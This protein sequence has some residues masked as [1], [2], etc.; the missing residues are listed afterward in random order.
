M[1]HCKIDSDISIMNI[2]VFHIHEKLLA[3]LILIFLSAFGHGFQRQLIFCKLSHND[4]DLE[5]LCKG[6]DYL[7]HYQTFLES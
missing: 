4:S 3:Q 7:T 1:R 6:M 5:K 2:R